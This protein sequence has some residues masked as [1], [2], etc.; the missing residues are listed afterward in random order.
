MNTIKFNLFAVA[1]C[2]L[3]ATPTTFAASGCATVI[4]V[5]SVNVAPM[6]DIYKLDKRGFSTGGGVITLLSNFG[7]VGSLTSVVADVAVGAIGTAVRL[8]DVA[9]ERKDEAMTE[10]YKDVF[11]ITYKPDF[12]DDLT[13]VVRKS[14]M[15]RFHIENGARVVMFDSGDGN[16]TTDDGPVVYRSRASIEVPQPGFWSL[17]YKVEMPDGENFSKE[18][19]ASCFKGQTKTPYWTMNA[20]NSPLYASKEAKSRAAMEA[21]KA[22]KEYYAKHPVR[23]LTKDEIEANAN[24]PVPLTASQIDARAAIAAEIASWN[25][26]TKPATSSK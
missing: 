17:T 18:Y 13:I 15:S 4:E 1:A 14:E 23:V 10:Q 21:D 7:A 24:L 6:A 11:Q 5:K 26:E 9:T 20:K 3:A 16:I 19:I 22:A 2:L 8:N 25:A 12:G